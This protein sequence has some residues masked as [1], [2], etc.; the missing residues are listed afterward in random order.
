M[1]RFSLYQVYGLLLLF[2][3][4]GE[5]QMR[6][7]GQGRHFTPPPVHSARTED[8]DNQARGV[9]GQGAETGPSSGGHA[10]LHPLPA[11]P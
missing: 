11:F 8:S 9:A 7:L 10:C 5:L 4:K 3:I 6:P 2:K 1:Q